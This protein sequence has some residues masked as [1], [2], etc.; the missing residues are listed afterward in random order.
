VHSVFGK[1]NYGGLKQQL[2]F[3]TGTAI[4]WVTAYLAKSSNLEMVPLAH[5]W[6][7]LI[8]R[9]TKEKTLALSVTSMTARE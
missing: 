2:I 3:G 4:W 1:I 9:L 5:T 8:K 6:A 7:G